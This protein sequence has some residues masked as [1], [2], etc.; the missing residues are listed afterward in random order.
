MIHGAIL[1]GLIG[2]VL[3]GVVGIML[4]FSIAFPIGLILGMACGGSFGANWV[5]R[6]QGKGPFVNWKP[7]HWMLAVGAF[8]LITNLAPLVLSA[9]VSPGTVVNEHS[10]HPV[11]LQLLGRLFT[12]VPLVGFLLLALALVLIIMN[13]RGG[14]LAEVHGREQEK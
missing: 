14:N 8:F 3:G 7:R 13:R 11:W 6:H 2:L 10:G 5:N 9:I 12:G 1:G 4:H